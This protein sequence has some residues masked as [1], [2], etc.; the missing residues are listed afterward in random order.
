M[1]KNRFIK[2][3]LFF[4]YIYFPTNLS[5]S[6]SLKFSIYPV[7]RHAKNTITVWCSV[8]PI[9]QQQLTF[10][11][12]EH[13]NQQKKSRQWRAL[14]TLAL[15]VHWEFGWNNWT[16]EIVL[17]FNNRDSKQNGRFFQFLSEKNFCRHSTVFIQI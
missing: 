16:I 11:F 3:L 13:M 1:S 15:L 4:L 17:I 7:S 12:R 9:A 5:F 2:L 10:D 6:L 8:R 14:T